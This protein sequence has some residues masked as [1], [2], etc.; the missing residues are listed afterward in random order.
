[1]AKLSEIDLPLP[2]VEK[3]DGTGTKIFVGPRF[4]TQTYNIFFST[5]MC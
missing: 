5:H 1:M 3:I 4:I 2:A